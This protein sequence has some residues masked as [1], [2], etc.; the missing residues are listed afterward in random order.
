MNEGPVR[1]PN[2]AI[3]C[4]VLGLASLLCLGFLAGIPAVIYGHKLLSKMNKDSLLSGRGIVI[5]GLILGYLGIAWSL[6]A[7]ALVILGQIAAPI[8]YTIF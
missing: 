5:A 1:I 7:I 8:I 4:L 3:A 6:L 2:N